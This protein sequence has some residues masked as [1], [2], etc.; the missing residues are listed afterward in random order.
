MNPFICDKKAS[1]AIISYKANKKTLDMLN[2][3]DIDYLL[4]KKHNSLPYQIDD[5]PDMMIHPINYNTL[6]IEKSVF[7]YYEILKKYDKKIIKSF[8]ELDLKYP[9]DIYLNVS[10]VGNYYF[11]KENF[12]DENLKKELDKINLKE[13]FI[14]QGYSRCS[15]MVI[16]ENTVITQDLKLHKKYTSLG[17]KSY[18][19][20][21]GGIELPGYDT[22]FIGGTCGMINRRELIFYGD[23]DNYIHGDILKKILKENN[24]GY[25]CPKDVKFIDRGSIIAI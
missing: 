15:T 2:S 1:L 10:R 25:N 24:I 12:I 21:P 5:H 19:L 8:R 7:N 20:P 11:H 6:I 3:L 23:I 14:K 18:L 13:I 16:G 9:N 4:T 22:G 17:L